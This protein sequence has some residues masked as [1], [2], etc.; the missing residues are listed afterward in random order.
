MPSQSKGTKSLSFIIH[1]RLTFTGLC[2]QRQTSPVSQSRTPWFSFMFKFYISRAVLSKADDAFLILSHLLEPMRFQLDV[3]LALEPEVADVTTDITCSLEKVVAAVSCRDLQVFMA[4]LRI[5]WAEGAIPAEGV[6]V[7]VYPACYM[8]RF[9]IVVHVHKVALLFD[10]C[11]SY[12]LLFLCTLLQ[13]LKLL[14]VLIEMRLFI[15]G[16]TCVLQYLWST[17]EVLILTRLP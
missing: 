6:Y 14:N 10:N 15:Q 2:C 13:C 4:T 17:R 16:L 11:Y 12:F 1:M 9:I 5:N 7:H 8:H 3:R